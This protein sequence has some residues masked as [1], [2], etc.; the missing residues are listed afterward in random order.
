MPFKR[1][2]RIAQDPWV[3]FGKLIR[4]QLAMQVKL[5][6]GR[7]HQFMLGHG[8]KQC[9]RVTDIGT[10]DGRF[11]GR[12]ARLYPEIR[13]TGVD[14]EAVMIGKA[15]RKKIPNVEW[16][17]ANATDERVIQLLGTTGGILMRY[18]VLHLPETK[19]LLPLILS[20]TCPGTKLW[21]FDLDTGYT[22][23][24]PPAQPFT[25]FQELVNTFCSSH[26]TEIRTGTMLPPI[27][28]TAG[29]ET[30]NISAEPFNN[31][32]IDP[33]LLAGYLYR[34]AVLYHHFLFGSH[35]SE[36]LRKMKD[37]FFG[38][39]LTGKRFV[40]YGM[41]MIVAEKRGKPA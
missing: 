32:E 3:E 35:D 37:F 39:M 20:R 17:L 13:F 31:R 25:L 24:D 18:F 34:E 7:H 8:L 28:E 27:L 11:L 38:E 10:G 30:R 26:A 19:R 9:D 1:S 41:A 21:I 22:V 4:E 23:C 14:D 15:K 12:L 5:S 6:F 40:Q 33:R 2:K 36:D 29:F 16:T